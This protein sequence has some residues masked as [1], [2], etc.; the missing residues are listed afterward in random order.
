MLREHQLDA[1]NS[2]LV[3]YLFVVIAIQLQ[4]WHEALLI[5]DQLL[6]QKPECLVLH[7]DRALCLIQ[8]DCL[9]EAE[10]CLVVAD[11][12]LTG[13]YVCDHYPCTFNHRHAA[14]RRAMTAKAS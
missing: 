5:V 14:R 7:L 4:R 1:V 12:V 2:P 3:R 13:C 6:K 10:T 11:C 8:L 9:D